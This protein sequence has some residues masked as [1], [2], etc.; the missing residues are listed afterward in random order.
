MP[1]RTQ[2]KE[3]HQVEKSGRAK[4]EAGIDYK[5]VKIR[6]TVHR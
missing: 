3:N 2:E 6:I 5:D 4:I 1:G